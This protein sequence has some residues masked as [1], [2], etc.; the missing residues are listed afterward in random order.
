MASV[1]VEY[2]DAVRRGDGEA[3]CERAFM[4]ETDADG[5]THPRIETPEVCRQAEIGAHPDAP[6][7]FV[8][9]VEVSGR[10]ARAHLSFEDTEPGTARAGVVDL[11]RFAE[12]WR[13]EFEPR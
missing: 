2:F 1:V 4:N 5:D 6:R 10:T 13:V 11:R 9:R 8:E 7:P 12:H 3:L